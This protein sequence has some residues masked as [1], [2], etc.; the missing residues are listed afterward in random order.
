MNKP[1]TLCGLSL[2]SASLDARMPTKPSPPPDTATPAQAPARQRRQ[3]VQ[4][5][6]TGMTV[7]KGLAR[8]GGRATLTGLAAHVQESPAKVHRY[9]ASLIEQGMVQQDAGTQDRK[10]PRLNSS[11]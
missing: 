10:S 3:R 11:H 1:V 6:E 8:L 9:L 5:A 2:S 7:L 4:A